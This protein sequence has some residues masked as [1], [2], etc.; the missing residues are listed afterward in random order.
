MVF[1]TVFTNA[2]P[3]T[4]VTPYVVNYEYS[5]GNFVPIEVKDDY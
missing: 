5:P 4:G 3:D 1:N 2:E